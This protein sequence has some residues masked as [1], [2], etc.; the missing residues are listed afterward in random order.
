LCPSKKKGSAG[1]SGPPGSSVTIA[2]NAAIAE[3]FRLEGFDAE[4]IS[5]KETD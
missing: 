1:Q 3:K 4:R 2:A 5:L